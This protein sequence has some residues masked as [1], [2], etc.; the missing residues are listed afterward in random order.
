MKKVWTKEPL[1]GAVA[2]AAAAALAA[3]VSTLP[4]ERAA[5]VGGVDLLSV[6]FADA[7]AIAG[8]ALVRKADRYFH[9]GV[10][11]DYCA[12]SPHA[13]ERGDH[14]PEHDPGAA[15]SA[16]PAPRAAGAPW[17]WINAR[18]HVQE[19]HHLSGAEADEMIPWIWAA[20]RADPR[21]VEAWE[22]GWYA[23]AKIRRLPEQGLAV[24]EA[25]IR[26]NPGSAQLEFTRGQSLLSDFKD[27]PASEAAFQLARAKALAPV[28]GAPEKLGEDEAFLLTHVLDYLAFFAEKRGDVAAIR[29]YYEEAVAADPNSVSTRDL[30]RRLEA[31]DRD[32]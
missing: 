31:A 4:P 21:N 18:V 14:D 26:E 9:G 5:Q 24:L 28:G 1:F 11:I 6:L 17:S 25:G 23:L 16:D 3:A 7:R 29:R 30:L 19:H 13:A 15:A 2:L 8:V 27:G 32:R 10:D 12:D 20:C 22:I